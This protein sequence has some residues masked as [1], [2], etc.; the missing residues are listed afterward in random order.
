LP[1]DTVLHSPYTRR[2]RLM[3]L[4]G[5]Q[6][7]L[8]AWRHEERDLATDFQRLFGDE[9][10]V[11]PPLRALLVGADADNTGGHSIAQVR[12]LQLR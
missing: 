2:V 5:S 1:R 9:S 4:H 12:G 10:S 3:V 7:P 8:Q 11:L 6:E